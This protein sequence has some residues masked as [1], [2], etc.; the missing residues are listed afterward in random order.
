VEPV[1]V[2]HVASGKTEMYPDLSLRTFQVDTAYINSC[3][4][5]SLTPEQICGYLKRMSLDAKESGAVSDKG[6]PMIQVDCPI[7]RSDVLHACDVMEDVA[8]SYGF[9]NL[10][11]TFPN[12]STIAKPLPINK[13]GDA[14]RQELALAGWS[15]VLPLIL[16]SHDENFAYLRRVDD[17]QHAVKLANPKTV[18]YQV[19]RTSMLPGLLKTLQSN[20]K[21]ALPIRLFEVADIVLKDDSMERRARNVRRVCALYCNK[22]SGFE[23]IHGLLDRLMAMLHTPLTTKDKTDDGYFIQ[24][25]SND[26]YFPGRCASI[27]LRINGTSTVVGAFGI[28]HPLVL[29]NFGIEFPCSVVEFD[30]EP[31]L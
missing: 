25:A 18:E 15:E 26:T 27:H 8:V 28:L 22:A 3:V 12:A 10:K 29:S 5:L 19:V 24:E 1:V 9:N 21:H 20:R 30:L 13:L 16:C 4:G 23:I 17:N 11:R 14:V 7:T 31:F 2:E 6:T